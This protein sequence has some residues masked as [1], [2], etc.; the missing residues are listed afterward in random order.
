MPPEFTHDIMDVVLPGLNARDTPTVAPF[1]KRALR[2]AIFKYPAG[3]GRIN[4]GC[5][6][7]Y[8][9]YILFTDDLRDPTYDDRVKAGVVTVPTNEF[10]EYVELIRAEDPLWVTFNI[11]A[12][13]Y[14]VASYGGA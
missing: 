1:V 10:A 7:G 12:P 5:E 9:L 6:D 8:R 13:S 3:G 14:V 2:H 11:E 4:L